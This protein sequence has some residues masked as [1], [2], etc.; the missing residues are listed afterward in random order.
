MAECANC[1]APLDTRSPL[2]NCANCGAVRRREVPR[3]AHSLRIETAGDVATVL[4]AQGTELPASVSEIFST[5]EAGQ[6]SVAIHLVEGE[7]EM[8]SGNRHLG[9]F[10]LDG[11]RAQPRGVPRIQFVL[12][13]SAEGELVV[14]AEEAGTE[15]RKT[16][17]GLI[18]RVE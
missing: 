3:L 14:E 11:L 6:S 9:R 12:R 7:H 13:V 5:H 4:L 1:G 8:V 17:R 18:V 10:Q 16:Y 15:N 2:A